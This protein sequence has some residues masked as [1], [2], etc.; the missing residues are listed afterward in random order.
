M[1]A[2]CASMDTTVRSSHKLNSRAHTALL[3]QRQ[4]LIVN[5]ELNKI[6]S[7]GTFVLVV[8]PGT[9]KVR[10]GKLASKRDVKLLQGE[11]KEQTS[12]ERM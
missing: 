3:L 12:G 9:N 8:H 7:S 4:I 1:L 5:V 2:V 11:R 6:L 10:I